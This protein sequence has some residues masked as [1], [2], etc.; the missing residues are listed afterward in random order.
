MNQRLGKRMFLAICVATSL[1]AAAC[2]MLPEQTSLSSVPLVSSEEYPHAAIVAKRS[3]DGPLQY[4]VFSPSEPTPSSAPLV[5]F[6]HGWGAV[7]P[8]AY[9]GWIE[10]L[11][12]KGNLVLYPRYQENMRT[13]PEQ[14][15]QN[16]Q[17]AIADAWQHIRDQTGI[18]PDSRAVGWIGH[19]LG[20]I[21]A[22]KLAAKANT[23]GLPPAAF[24][25]LVEP[26]GQ[27]RIAMDDIRMLPADTSVLLVTGDDDDT[28]A[29]GGAEA[30]AARL[31]HLSADRLRRIRLTSDTTASP[32]LVADHFAPLSRSEMV[33]EAM[34][35]AG[36]GES[37]TGFAM[38]GRIFRGGTAGRF[39]RRLTPD[40]L[41][42][43][44]LWKPVS[45]LLDES[46][47]KEK[48]TDK[49]VTD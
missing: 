20:A 5:V 43:D 36:V 10:F 31:G 42:L 41:D 6:M 25:F 2:N 46:F 3:G 48:S 33:N 45:E 27:D 26:G 34:A 23:T 40:S 14:M 15:T 9:G 30:I 44:G 39:A 18:T 13:A 28:V 8:R 21:L 22:A 19:S 16:A 38:L 17:V 29:D 24:L 12:R 4:W 47:G 7:N 1:S 49:E 35:A 11:V 37:T 32:Q